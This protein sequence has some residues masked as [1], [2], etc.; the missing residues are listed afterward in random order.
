MN[1]STN[2]QTQ[3]E[4]DIGEKLATLAK[5]KGLSQ[6]KLAEKIDVSRVSINRFFKGKSSIRTRDLV[7]LLKVLDIDL[8]E[9]ISQKLQSEMDGEASQEEIYSDLIS[10]LDHLDNHARSSVIEQVVWWG[11]CGLNETTRKASDR[12]HATLS[13][14]PLAGTA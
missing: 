1:E 8:E 9:M 5:S 2:F 7:L 3:Q 13:Q 12:L 6:G 10:I 14:S 4:S 11:R